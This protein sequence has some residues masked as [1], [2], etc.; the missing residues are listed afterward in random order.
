[1][2]QDGAYYNNFCEIFICC[3]SFISTD[4]HTPWEGVI[5]VSLINQGTIILDQ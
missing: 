1:M 4:G 2:H 3:S 5:I